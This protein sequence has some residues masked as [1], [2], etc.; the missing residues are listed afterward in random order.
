MKNLKP[1]DRFDN[2]NSTLIKESNEITDEI[3][4]LVFAM[5]IGILGLAIKYG[6]VAVLELFSNWF[7]DTITNAISDAI[8][9]IKSAIKPNTMQKIS[10]RLDKNTEFNKQVIEF[11]SKQDMSE[12]SAN[13]FAEGLT[14][15]KEFKVI[16]DEVVESEGI[17]LEKEKRK[18][19]QNV[20]DSMADK[21]LNENNDIFNK[22]Q[23]RFPELSK[24]LKNKQK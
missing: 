21:F 1:Y 19:L 11:L 5:I 9:S 16:F 13:E 4:S 22:I 2:Q 23:K 24:G 10:K 8:S 15:L 6:L 7:S 18:L 12:M 3:K 17:V 20:K 14:Q